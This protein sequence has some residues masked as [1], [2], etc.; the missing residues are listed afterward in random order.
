[1]SSTKST[2]SIWDVLALL[3]QI[4]LSVFVLPL[5]VSCALYLLLGTAVWLWITPLWKDI[6]GEWD[7]IGKYI[8][9]VAW[10]FC[11]PIAFNLLL[12]CVVGI[13]FDPL[14]AKVD[15]ILHSADY[16]RVPTQVQ[17]VDS[18]VRTI[19]LLAL[20]GVALIIGLANPLVGVAVSG[21]SS[22]L[23]AAIIV[24]TPAA[25]HRGIRLST[26]VKLLLA[27]AGIRELVFGVVAA[28]LLNN[29]L[30]QVLSLVPLVVVGQ[31]FVRRWAA[32]ASTGN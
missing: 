25:T 16:Q 24:T 11:F 1:M 26:H 27:N 13:A 2:Q 9:V 17:W 12:S 19:I 3:R 6:A 23:C 5:L 31:L 20:Q 22:V 8:A 21:V 30:L 18:I 7:V 15:E 10:I 29:P 28:V 32:D 14:A 4:P